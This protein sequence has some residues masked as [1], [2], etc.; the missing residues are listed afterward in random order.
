LGKDPEGLKKE[1]SEIG[2]DKIK[3]WY[4]PMNFNFQDENQFCDAICQTNMARA[5]LA[6][7]GSEEKREEVK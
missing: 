2:F 5:A 4:Q 6:N 7:A 1:M 3:M